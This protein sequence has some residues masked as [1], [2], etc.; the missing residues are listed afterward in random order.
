MQVV[1]GRRRADAKEAKGAMVSPSPCRRRRMF[2]DRAVGGGVMVRVR[3]G[4]KSE[5]WGMGGI[6]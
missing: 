5:D 1:S 4:G 3:E 2:V 6:V